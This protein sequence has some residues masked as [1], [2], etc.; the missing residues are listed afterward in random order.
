[1]QNL[2]FK[3]KVVLV[4]GG[5]R[6]IGRAIV[7]RFAQ[8]GATVWF[9]YRS[10]KGEAQ[11]LEEKYAGKVKGFQGD[12][13]D[14]TAMEE[15][16]NTIVKEHGRIDVLV[17][18]AGIARDNLVLRMK[19][20]EWQQVIDVNLT[21][22][23]RLIKFV[24]KPMLKQRSGA[25][26]NMSSI[27]GL[28]SNPG[29]ANYAASKAGLIA[30]TK[31][32][33]KEVGKRNIRVNAIAPGF[34]ETDMTASLP[35]QVKKEYLSNIALGRFGKPEEVAE[36]VLFLASDRASYITGQTIVVCGG[37]YSG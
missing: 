7:E 18:N 14:A 19:D 4:T 13:A 8:E 22:A 24:L 20:E 27:V 30:L 34:I 35:E 2:E 17:N 6:G 32:V 12:V 3:D 15:L 5:S 1:M 11:E 10:S 31:A 29:Q 26:V 9:T 33:A 37:L 23:F 21:A 16:V 28:T 36:V 25:I